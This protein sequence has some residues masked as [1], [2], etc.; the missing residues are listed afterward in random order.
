MGDETPKIQRG[1]R[2]VK[3]WMLILGAI[4]F[5][6]SGLT[7]TSCGVG[8]TTGKYIE[9]TEA[10]GK[11]HLT[12]E[13]D[14]EA[15]QEGTLLVRG[16]LKNVTDWLI[17]ELYVAMTLRDKEGEIL[18]TIMGTRELTVRIDQLEPGEEKEF[19]IA[20][21]DGDA[22][23]SFE[24]T[25]KGFDLTEVE[26]LPEIRAILSPES[27]T[28]G[29]SVE[30]WIDWEEYR[31]NDDIVV[32]VKIKNVSGERIEGRK[33]IWIQFIDTSGKRLLY[34][35]SPR[36]PGAGPFCTNHLYLDPGKEVVCDY[37]L[38]RVRF[39]TAAGTSI[40]DVQSY[41]LTVRFERR[42]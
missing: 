21:P 31:V 24:I 15:A 23:Q 36:H 17:R 19:E 35:V 22:I 33:G 2:E 4:L 1:Q 7:V 6:V 8:T 39:E 26:K 28:Q 3:K 32:K 34:E 13:V 9:P 25:L 18:L 11:I 12:Y 27:E 20:H 16:T 40:L 5:L 41:I 42:T 38:P 30:S 14:N 29:L 37:R 10:K